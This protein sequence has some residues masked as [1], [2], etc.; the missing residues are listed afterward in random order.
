MKRIFAFFFHGKIPAT[1]FF[2]LCQRGIYYKRIVLTNNNYNWMTPCIS[3][4]NEK[5]CAR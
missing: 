1:A 5:M 2:C 4:A 3:N